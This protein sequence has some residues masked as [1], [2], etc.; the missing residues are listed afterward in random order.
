MGSD[1]TENLLTRL[2]RAE[3]IEFSAI[4]FNF[5]LISGD[6]DD[7]K[8]ADLYLTA[9]ADFLVSNDSKILA[10]NALEFPSLEVITIQQFSKMLEEK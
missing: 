1:V 10:L 5:N 9:N 3:N 8:F 6:E 2:V 7:N 4:F